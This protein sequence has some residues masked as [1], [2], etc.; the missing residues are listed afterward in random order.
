M[1][2]TYTVLMLNGPNLGRLGM[3]KPEIYGTTTLA[4]IET[5]VREQL[6]P[7]GSLIAVQSNAESVLI[8]ALEAHRE[9]FGAIVNPGA[10]M[11]AGWSLRDALEAFERPWVEVHISNV[12]A[13]ES[14]RHHSVLSAIATG[15]ISGLGTE[16]YT[17]AASYLRRAWERTANA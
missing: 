15:Q 9:C 14:F 10:L 7:Q 3:R 8:D 1:S 17:L 5:A 2:T 6:G 13:R 12:Y 4:D 11:M 16:G